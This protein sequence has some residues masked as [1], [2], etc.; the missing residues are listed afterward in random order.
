MDAERAK[1]VALR[2]LTVRDRTT[3]EIRQ[4]LGKRGAEPEV[5]DQVVTRLT[6]V[7]LLDDTKFAASWVSS[8]QSGRSLSRSQLGRELANRGV[9]ESDVEQAL[10]S[11]S[12]SDT[13]V[14]LELARRRVRSM[15]GL[16]AATKS[17]RLSG[18]LARR[19]FSWSV[20][21]SVVA[22]V[23]GEVNGEQPDGSIGDYE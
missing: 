12:G 6:D 14:A 23:V 19:G 3:W 15:S 20:V 18:Q 8:R 4:E 13:E 10:E 7:G 2:L 17:R 11:A 21:R 1:D 22:Q 9:G 16:D 5:V